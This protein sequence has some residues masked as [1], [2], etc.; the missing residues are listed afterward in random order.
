MLLLLLLVVV[1][2]LQGGRHGDWGCGGQNGGPATGSV[3]GLVELGRVEDAWG[4]RYLAARR[5]SSSWAG[6]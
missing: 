2:P 6:R 3:E 4:G 5:V 1:P